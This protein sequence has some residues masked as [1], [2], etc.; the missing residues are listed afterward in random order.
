MDCHSFSK[1]E[2]KKHLSKETSHLC[3]DFHNTIDSTHTLAKELVSTKGETPD[4]IIA[5]MQTAGYGRFGKS[6]YSPKDTGIYMNFI[7]RDFPIPPSFV[8]M[9]AGIAVCDAISDTTGVQ[10]SMKWVNDIFLNGKKV[11]G[12]LMEN[13]P[14]KDGEQIYI[15]GIGINFNTDFKQAEPSE[16]P[17]NIATSL[18]HNETPR[19]TRS[20]LTA[21]IINHIHKCKGYTDRDILDRYKNLLFI[22]GK[23]IK[24]TQ[25]KH[26]YYATALDLDSAGHLIIKDQ[27]GTIKTIIAGEVSVRSVI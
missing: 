3:I 10:T 2:I 24:V 20:E 4:I 8:T 21:S 5:N 25:G 18:F 7:L 14:A 22:L 17:N 6:F 13:M 16:Q 15:L 1:E 27:D 11:G 12:I 9:Y 26:I 23:D 19:A